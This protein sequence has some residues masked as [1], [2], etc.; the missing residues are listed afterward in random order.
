MCAAAKKAK[1]SNDPKSKEHE[2]YRTFIFFFAVTL[3]HELG[4]V[5]ITFLS[6]GERDSPEEMVPKLIDP[7]QRDQAE[8]G[9]TLEG[10][11]FGGYVIHARDDNYDESQVHLSISCSIEDIE[12]EVTNALAWGALPSHQR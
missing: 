1:E 3:F 10:L 7:Y 9:I 8:A 5:F 6:L 12:R 11:V 2:Q 4:H